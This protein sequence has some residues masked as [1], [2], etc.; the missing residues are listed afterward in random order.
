MSVHLDGLVSKEE[1]RKATR[2]KDST[3]NNAIAALK[4]RNIIIPK[5]S[6]AGLYRLPSQS[7][8]VW[9]RGYTQQVV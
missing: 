4:Q 2:P 8:A 6:K 5:E 9:I 7:F 1:I 3:L